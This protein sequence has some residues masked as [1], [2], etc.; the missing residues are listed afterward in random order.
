MQEKRKAS[1]SAWKPGQ[2]GNPKGRPR[3]GNALAERVRAL[4][5]PDEIVEFAASRLRGHTKDGLEI[6]VQE[7]DRQWA[8]GFLRDAGYSKPLQQIEV[9]TPSLAEAADIRKLSTE[10]LVAIA[11]ADQDAPV[12]DDVPDSPATE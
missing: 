3:T 6:A 2:S 4:V 12:D 9:S 1:P 8:A 7:K 5:D 10:E 11:G